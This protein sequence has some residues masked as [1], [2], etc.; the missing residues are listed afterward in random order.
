MVFQRKTVAIPVILEGLGLHSG[1]PVKVTIHP[2]D[3]GIAFHCGGTRVAALPENVT[4]TTR[5]T[6]LGDISTIE[7]LMSAFCGL[8]ITDAE[9]ELTTPELPA[10]DGSAKPYALA[11]ADAGFADLGTQEL[12][13]PFSRVFVQEEATKIAIGHGSGHWRYVFDAGTRFPGLQAY[14]APRITEGYSGKIA[15]A[16]TFGFLDEIPVLLDMG[17]AKGLNLET[18]L[19]LGDEGY[20]NAALFDDEPARHKLLDLM[21]DLYLSGVPARFLNVVAERSGHRMNVR[22]AGLLRDAVFGGT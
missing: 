10:L 2:G 3:Q 14:E 9:V 20:Q 22:A 15:P 21:G 8:E 4:E 6:K 5:C 18:A 17:L 11:L 7:H 13:D 19:V 16:R 1:D 12:N